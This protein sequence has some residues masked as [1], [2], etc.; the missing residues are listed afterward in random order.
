[1]ILAIVFISNVISE[2]NKE[3]IRSELAIETYRQSTNKP[4]NTKVEGHILSPRVHYNMTKL[5]NIRSASIED[6]DGNLVTEQNP[7]LTILQLKR[8][9]SD[10]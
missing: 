9:F 2:E 6:N 7:I 8:Q 5:N 1:M 4:R 10:N 3:R